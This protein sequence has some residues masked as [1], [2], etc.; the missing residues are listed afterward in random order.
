MALS[1]VKSVKITCCEHF[2][3][4]GIH[5]GIPL[6]Y[7][8]IIVCMYIYSYSFSVINCAVTHYIMLV[9]DVASPQLMEG[10]VHFGLMHMQTV[11]A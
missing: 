6:I 2:Q 8:F 4:Y 3:V 5:L 9:R 1:T 11:T 7:G 10:D